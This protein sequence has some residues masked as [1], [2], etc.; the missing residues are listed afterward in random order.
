MITR[1][2]IIGFMCFLTLL[3]GCSLLP[4]PGE[5]ATKYT[6]TPVKG[7]LGHSPMR[8]PHQLALELPTIYTPLDNNRI[9]LVPQER[10][11]E[12]YADVEWGD[13]LSN[14]IQDSLV[15]SFQ[16]SGYFQSVARA[17]EGVHA[18]LAI[19]CDVR[20]FY[21]Q[22]VASSSINNSPKH[23][24]VVEYYVQVIRLP[25]REIIASR[26]F[27][28]QEPVLGEKMGKYIAALDAAQ[29]GLVKEIMQWVS[30]SVS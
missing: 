8:H 4:Q 19:K 5:P 23:Q 17:A 9:A 2:K 30:S 16:N 15:Y 3:S 27:S 22:T 10:Q 20:K 26:I 13:R 7:V 1:H 11:I 29:M 14:I 25:E 6:L 24:A 28:H 21:I 12:Y 18:N